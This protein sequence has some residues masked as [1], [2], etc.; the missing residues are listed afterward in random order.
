MKVELLIYA[1]L[2]ICAAMIGFNIVCIFVFRRKERMLDKHSKKFTERVRMQIESGVVEETH[3]KYLARKLKR[4]GNLTAFDQTLSDMHAEYPE[5]IKTYIASLASVFV[6]LTLTY[7]KKNKL[8]A[9]YFPYLIKKYRVF[10]GRDI[11]LITDILLALVREPSLYCRQNA[12]QALYSIGDADCVIKALCSVDASEFYHH[13]KLISDGLLEFSGDKAKLAE[14]LWNKF[15]RFSETMQVTVLDY[16]RFESGMYGEKMLEL[17][18]SGDRSDEAAYCCI[19]YFGKYPN[20]AAYPH[21]L[22]YAKDTDES[23]W[24]Y[25][26]IAASA[27][28]SY[29][30]GQTVD[31]LKQILS[32]RNWYVR[33]NAS[34]SL[35]TLGLTYPDLIDIFEGADRFAGEM[36]RYR[37]DQKR[38]RAKRAEE[39]V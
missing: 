24:E 13:P 31:T 35:E 11:R 29:P 39:R 5:Q 37:L 17:L 38:M 14:A 8:Q 7:E 32:S 10:E 19:R 21:L 12:L 15:P 27:L 3:C 22:M 20:E 6:Y 28:A 30:D 16:F 23:R 9:A 36:M 18:L 2:V 34:K 25:A 4:I 1:Y 26:A 33:F